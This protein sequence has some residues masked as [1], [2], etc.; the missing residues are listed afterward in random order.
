MKNHS[1]AQ[2]PLQQA[3]VTEAHVSVIPGKHALAFKALYC[4]NKQAGTTLLEEWAAS[5]IPKS[6]TLRGTLSVTLHNIPKRATSIFSRTLGS[7]TGPALGKCPCKH[8]SCIQ[9][10]PF[11]VWIYNCYSSTGA[12][13]KHV[14][15]ALEMFLPSWSGYPIRAKDQAECYMFS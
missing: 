13:S 4:S 15:Q 5:Y 1:R 8:H 14:S 7:S 2:D 11:F 10:F 6:A 12:P 9:M 3:Q